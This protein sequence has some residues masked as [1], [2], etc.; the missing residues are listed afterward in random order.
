MREMQGHLTAQGGEGARCVG[1][2]GCGEGV[3]DVDSGVGVG[4]GGFVL[5]SFVGFCFGGVLGLGFD[6][7]FGWVKREGVGE[8]EV[9]EEGGCDGYEV[10]GGGEE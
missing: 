1:E 7:G 2:V 6:F 3:V 5:Y 10:E 8:E 4:V 9:G